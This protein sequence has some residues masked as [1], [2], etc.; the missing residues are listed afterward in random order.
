MARTT[1][2]HPVLGSAIKPGLVVGRGENKTVIPPDEVEKLAQLHCSSEE[3]AAFF[4]VPSQTLVA[5]FGD[6][7]QKAR[8]EMKVALRRSQIKL[9]LDGNCTMLIWLGKQYLN[10]SDKVVEE[11]PEALNAEELDK[12]IASLLS[13]INNN[14]K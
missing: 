9:A 10:Q 8:A 3:I 11:K 12:R 6:I 13:T 2:K 4:G 14:G 1:R 5:N 7:I